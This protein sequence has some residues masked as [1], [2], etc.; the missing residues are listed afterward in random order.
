MRRVTIV[1][2]MLVLA[3]CG[4]V[5]DDSDTTSPAGRS[6][7]TSPVATNPITTSPVR[8]TPPTT[9]PVSTSPITTSPVGASACPEVLDVALVQSSPGVF[10]VNTTVRSLDVPGVSFAD[11]WEVRDSD[12]N[13]LG[14][15]ILAHD[16]ANEQPFT[17]SLS[18]VEIPTDVTRIEVEARDSDR[19]FC[20]E[21]L[22]VEVDHS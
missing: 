20:G 22:V 1:V 13:V 18:G 6:V 16:H 3:A 7:T 10:T 19:G 14:T 12:G 17:R 5:D 2:F 11:A 4:G 9:S 8:S 21:P 15:R